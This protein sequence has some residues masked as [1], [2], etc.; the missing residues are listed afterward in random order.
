[1]DK[2]GTQTDGSNSKEIDDDDQCLKLKRWF[3]Q[4]SMCQEKEGDNMLL[5]KI[6]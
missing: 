2:R 5:L 6:E 4:T 3:K 1:M